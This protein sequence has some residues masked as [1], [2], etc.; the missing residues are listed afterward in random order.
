MDSENLVAGQSYFIMSFYDHGFRTPEIRTV[1]YI[2]KN[3]LKQGK[4]DE[5]YFQD[6]DSYI[7]YGSFF[8]LPKEMERVV[9][10]MD[11][12]S[13]SLIRDLAGLIRDLTE[14]KKGTYGRRPKDL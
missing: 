4:K 7:E 9:H 1:I 5:W 13:L 2:G 12:E 10:V 6:A 11:E 14:L 3:L 8:K